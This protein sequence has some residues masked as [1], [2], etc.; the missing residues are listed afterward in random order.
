MHAALCRLTH[1][2]VVTL[3]GLE[4]ALCSSSQLAEAKTYPEAQASCFA[5]DT[6]PAGLPAAPGVEGLHAGRW[7]GRGDLRRVGI[8]VIIVVT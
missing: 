8:T 5:A 4:K 2:L 6:G 3:W 7:L 1:V